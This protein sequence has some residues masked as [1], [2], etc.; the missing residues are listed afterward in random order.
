MKVWILQTGEPLHID[1]ND[2]RPMRAMNL[3]NKLL[4]N[5]HEVVIWSSNFDHF[6]KS[7]RSST[8]LNFNVSK[9]LEIILIP[10]TGYKSNISFVRLL[11]HAQMAVNLLKQL[12]N[13]SLPEIVFVGYPPIET[14][15]VMTR[16]CRKRHI[17]VL[18]DVKDAWPEIL[19]RALPNKF[20][21]IGKILLT[22]YTL[23]MKN[24]FKNVTG[25][26]APSDPFLEW[27]L[28]NSK[29][30][31]NIFDIVVP[32]TTPKTEFRKSDIEN[33][34]AW[35]DS[36]GIRQDI[37]PIISFVGSLNSAFDFD[38]IITVAAK[39]KFQL[40]IAGNGPNYNKI[41]AQTLGI[42]N[43]FMPGWLT[44]CQ[45]QV[46]AQRSQLMIAPLRNLKDFKMSIP[47]KFFDYMS[48]GKPIITS[49][50]GLAGEFVT[51]NRIGIEYSTGIDGSLEIVLLNLL[52]K[53]ELINEMSNNSKSIFLAKF[54]YDVVYQKLVDHINRVKNAT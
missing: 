14:A 3:A 4:E 32:L 21:F 35:L 50:A 19:I 53:P 18:L 46:L 36:I 27:S 16:W 15:W 47:N 7:H 34:A 13:Q 22:P 25:F 31:K 11:D 44:H 52:E 45:A 24:T 40:V 33:A 49:I 6:S 37:G 54:T 26:C 10:S 28:K 9:N 48:N 5:G 41:K 12:K 43:I 30:S 17:P 20:K 8:I 42:S 23:M 1:T 29:R 38:P 2:L 51:E 39:S